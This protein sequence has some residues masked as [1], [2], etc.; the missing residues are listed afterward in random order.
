MVDPGRTQTKRRNYSQ[1]DVRRLTL[2][3]SLIDLGHKLPHLA[4]LTTD[5]LADRLREAQ[6]STPSGPVRVAFV[7]GLV[8]EALREAAADDSTLRLVGEFAEL[9]S[10]KATLRPGSVDL[11]VIE[12]P[13]LFPEAIPEIQSALS[14]LE[15]HRVVVIYQF[16]SELTIHS[17]AKKIPGIRALRGPVSADELR[18]V[19]LTG[20]LVHGEA[21]STSEGPEVKAGRIPQRRYSDAQLARAARLSSA[22]KCECPSHLAQL[23]SSLA[24]FESYSAQCENRN[25]EDARLHAHLHQ[26]TAECRA[27][28]E[29]ALG[30]LLEMEEVTL[31][32]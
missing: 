15:I 5:A 29:E 28:M 13:S 10:L 7:G 25:A 19:L 4:S 14:L 3:K 17:L 16:A 21:P 20:A 1:A 9:E 32:G 8:I 24:A 31:E 23:I 30:Q 18:L 12:F 2:I 22:V 27:K 11:I 6:A 26:A